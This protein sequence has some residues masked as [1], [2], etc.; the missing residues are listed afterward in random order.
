MKFRKVLWTALLLTISPFY[1]ETNILVA[2]RYIRVRY[3]DL[4][5]N[6]NTTLA[7]LYQHLNLPFTKHVQNVAFARTHAEN[8]TGTHGWAAAW[9]YLDPLM[10]I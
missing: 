6:T 1:A 10:R 8:V 2:A 5:D 4:V 9:K 7:T 3:E